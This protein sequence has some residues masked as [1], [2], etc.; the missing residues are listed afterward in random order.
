MENIG[1][2]L[3]A[4]YAIGMNKMDLFQTVDL[5]EARNIPQVLTG[6]VM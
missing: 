2:F 4:C 1:N 3:E 6:A 5:F